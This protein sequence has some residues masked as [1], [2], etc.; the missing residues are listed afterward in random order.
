MSGVRRRRSL[1]VR[2]LVGETL[3]YD[4]DTHRASCLNREAAAV[5]DAC[6]G[7]RSLPEIRRRVARTL[8]TTV[9][10]G[11]VELALDRL[12]RSGLLEDPPGPPSRARREMLRRL[13]ATAALALPLVTSV[14]A[15]EPA[16]AQS[17]LPN[18]SPCNANG[19]CCSGSCVG[20]MDM[21]CIGSGGGM[22]MM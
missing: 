12:S 13:T 16:S 19:E 10:D 22:M 5:L 20:M 8:E 2:R 6:D 3:V 9:A 7:R 4:L 18:G 1:L 11:Y 14:I 21:I 15:P 17:C